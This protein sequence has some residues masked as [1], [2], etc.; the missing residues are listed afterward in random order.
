MM[1][2]FRPGVALIDIS[3]SQPVP[4]QILHG[5]RVNVAITQICVLADNEMPPD[6]ALLRT[7][8]RQTARY[9]N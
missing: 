3:I 5:V 9:P 7:C 1:Q 4:A 6:R 8:A 2:R